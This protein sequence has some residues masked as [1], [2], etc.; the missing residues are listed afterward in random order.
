MHKV[1]GI[2]IGN[3]FQLGTKYSASMHLTYTADDGTEQ[4]P[5]MGCY[6]IGVG[7]TMAAILEESADE[8]GPR[9]NMAT[10]P[11]A[12]QVIA[13]TDKDGKTNATAE[14]IYNDLRAAGIETL[15]DTRDARAGE[16]FAD[17]DLIAAPVRLIISTKNLANGVAEVKYRVN[18]MDTSGMPTSF[19]LDTVVADT[20]NAIKQLSK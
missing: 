15:L 6:G 14:K 10:A 12:V 19:A 18:D 7:R 2:E 11:F 20:Q 3:I 1:R 17:A 9:W 13:L 5:I 4:N 16:K 8:Y